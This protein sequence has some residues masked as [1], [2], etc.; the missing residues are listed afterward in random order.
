[1]HL[2]LLKVVAQRT[3]PEC[4]LFSNVTII[5]F[6]TFRW[7]HT[8]LHLSWGIYTSPH[9]SAGWRTANKNLFSRWPSICTTESSRAHTPIFLARCGIRKTV[10]GC[11]QRKWCRSVYTYTLCLKLEWMTVIDVKKQDKSK[12]VNNFYNDIC[13]CRPFAKDRMMHIDL[14]WACIDSHFHTDTQAR[15]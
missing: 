12:Q 4:V 10:D 8:I 3:I 13:I 14:T 9:S 6:V 11:I 15:F 2:G 1:M 5:Y 7:Y